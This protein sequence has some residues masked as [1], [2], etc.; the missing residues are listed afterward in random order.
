MIFSGKNA[1]EFYRLIKNQEIQ[2]NILNLE[3]TTLGRFDIHYF[4][5]I[6][7]ENQTSLVQDFFLKSKDRAQAK[8]IFATAD[9]KL[10]KIGHRGSLNHYRVYLKQKEIRRLVYDQLVYGLQFELELKGNNIKKF[11]NLLL[12]NSLE[13]IQNFEKYLSYQFYKYSLTRL[14]LSTSCT[15]WLLNSYR[16]KL[17]EQKTDHF[18]VTDYITKTPLKSFSQKES[19]FRLFQLIAFL[20]TKKV[21][22]KKEEYVGTQSYYSLEFLLSDYLQFIEMTGTGGKGQSRRKKIKNGLISLQGLSPLVKNFSNHEFQSFVI[23]PT[24]NVIKRGKFLVVQMSM[25]KQLFDYQ[26]PFVLPRSFL[27]Y[28]SKYDLQVKLEL[29]QSFCSLSQKK[30]IYIKKFLHQF[31]IPNKQIKIIKKL[32]VM[33]LND[34]D[35]FIEPNFEITKTNGSVFKTDKITLRNIKQSRIISFKEAI[36]IPKLEFLLPVKNK[37]K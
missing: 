30:E 10:L 6:E 26:Y 16:T 2:W 12:S 19:L 8:G 20:R 4:L 32:F 11:Q 31:S 17:R 9:S 34:L 29:L 15:H 28:K 35:E 18:M 36:Y 7:P 27:Y 21:T 37:Y 13:D 24:I 23:F 3:N 5:I 33:A 25:A 1:A 14:D 22:P